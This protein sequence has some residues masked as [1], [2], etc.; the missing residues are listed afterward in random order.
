MFTRSLRPLLTLALSACLLAAAVGEALAQDESARDKVLRVCADPD[1]LPLSNDRGEGYENKIAERLAQD[2]GRKIEYTYFPQRLGFVRNTLKKQDP[3]TQQFKCDVIIGVPKGYE[4]TATTRPYM[5]STYALLFR[6]R[7]EFEQLATA[8]DLLKLPPE[9]LH[10]LRIGVFA[11][12]PGSDWLLRNELLD[13]AVFY[14]SQSGDPHEN[15]ASTVSRDLDAGNIDAAIVW[16][17]VAGFLMHNHSASPAWRAV[18]FTPDKQIKFDY[19]ISMGV[20]F[21][22][23][24]WKATLDDWIARNEQNVNQILATYLVPL[25]DA[26]GNIKVDFRSSE[27]EL[28]NGVAKRIPLQLGLNGTTP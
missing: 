20:R 15:P 21:G 13:R 1:N 27:R 10:A 23:K 6:H 26:D 25:L 18:P 17:P 16:G 8:E 24:E 3:M 7:S 19:E 14:A 4:L 28:T 11:Q 5:H 9:K 2:L 22:E 12:S